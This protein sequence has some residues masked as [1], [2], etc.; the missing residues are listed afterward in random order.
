VETGIVI[1]QE[2]LEYPGNFLE[3]PFQVIIDHKLATN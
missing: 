1:L 3:L 2:G